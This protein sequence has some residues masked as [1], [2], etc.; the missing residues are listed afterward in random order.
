MIWWF[1]WI[2]VG[3]TLVGPPL[4]DDRPNLPIATKRSADSWKRLINSENSSTTTKSAGNG[5][6]GAPERRALE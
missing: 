6:S 4:A 2:K 1:E 5:A 3:A